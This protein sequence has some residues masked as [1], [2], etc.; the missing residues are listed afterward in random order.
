M[1]CISPRAPAGE[2]A[3]GCHADSTQIW[4]ATTSGRT[5][6][7]CARLRIQGHSAAL[8]KAAAPSMCSTT[9]L[10]TGHV[11]GPS[12]ARMALG[13]PARDKEEGWPVR[14][15]AHRPDLLL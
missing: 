8:R 14:R 15:A 3:Q 6:C 7:S 11:A 2:T 9:D 1:S 10:L 5:E 12:S 13:C 4:A